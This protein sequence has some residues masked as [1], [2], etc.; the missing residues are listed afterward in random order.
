M[1]TVTSTG[2]L[3][4][5]LQHQRHHGARDTTED[6]FSSGEPCRTVHRGPFCIARSL[7]VKKSA[8]IRR[9]APEAIVEATSELKRKAILGCIDLRVHPPD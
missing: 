3:C 1:A 2:P 4:G 8:I 5:Y 9:G 7:R 6:F